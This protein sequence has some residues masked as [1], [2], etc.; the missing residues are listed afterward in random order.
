MNRILL[1]LRE[2]Q[3]AVNGDLIV[4]L[5]ETDVRT[6]HVK[7]ILKA[8]VGDVLRVAVENEGLC[9]GTVVDTDT[10]LKLRLGTITPAREL[11]PVTLVLALPRPRAAKRAVR[12]AAQMG[13]SKICLVGATRVEKSFFE[14]KDTRIGV[15]IGMAREGVMQAAVDARVPQVTKEARLWKIGAQLPD[16]ATKIVLHPAGDLSL[17]EVLREKDARNI[18]LAV[19]P[20]GGWLD[21][22]VEYLKRQG[23]VRAGLGARILSSEVAVAV[24][25][26]ITHEYLGSATSRISEL[27]SGELVGR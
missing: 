7:K 18:V 22:E 4:I 14:A 19:G 11:P 27:P 12:T 5:P 1:L 2:I 6:V 3:R 10:D 9:D 17:G 21:S 13:V 24:A 26:T 23:F 8:S 25:V 16:N 15:L 20:E